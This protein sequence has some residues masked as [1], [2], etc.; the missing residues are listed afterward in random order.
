MARSCRAGGS[1]A[2]IETLEKRELM[3]AAPAAAPKAPLDRLWGK[4][5]LVMNANPNDPNQFK[6]TYDV[7]INHHHGRSFDGWIYYPGGRQRLRGAAMTDGIFR[8]AIEHKHYN[9]QLRAL[10]ISTTNEWDG[11]W[12]YNLNGKDTP[13]HRGDTIGTFTLSRPA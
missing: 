13:S 7:K 6:Q 11:I 1:V 9:G 2:V 5:Q 10:Y 3:S 12:F 4:F 8:F